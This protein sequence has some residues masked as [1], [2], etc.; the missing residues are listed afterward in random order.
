[1]QVGRFQP[2][3]MPNIP[4]QKTWLQRFGWMKK[5]FVP[6]WENQAALFIIPPHNELFSQCPHW[7]GN[8]TPARPWERMEKIKFF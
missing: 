6:R 3:N 5:R 7:N 2:G 1:M 8:T 4:T